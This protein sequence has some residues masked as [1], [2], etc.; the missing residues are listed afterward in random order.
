MRLDEIALSACVWH[1]ASV[2]GRKTKPPLRLQIR[3]I[4]K[5]WERMVCERSRAPPWGVWGIRGSTALG[6]F[7]AYENE[8]F[9]DVSGHSQRGFAAM[10]TLRLVTIWNCLR[11]WIVEHFTTYVFIAYPELLAARIFQVFSSRAPASYIRLNSENSSSVSWLNKGC[12]A[13]KNA[14]SKFSPMF[15]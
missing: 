1:L 5:I 4:T 14:D 9:V 3:E 8:W 7:A 11:V 12:V 13:P 10:S 2:T 15:F 6:G